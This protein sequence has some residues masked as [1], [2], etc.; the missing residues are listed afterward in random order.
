MADLSHTYVQPP[1]PGSRRRRTRE[2]TVWDELGDLPGY[3]WVTDEK[4]DVMDEYVRRASEGIPPRTFP[5]P[6]SN[7]PPARCSLHFPWT[8]TTY[9]KPTPRPT[10]HS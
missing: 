4:D 5:S 10:P 6:P 9:T 8:N 1:P 7:S 3:E 2:T